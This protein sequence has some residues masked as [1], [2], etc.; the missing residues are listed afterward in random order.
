MRDTLRR[1][2]TFVSL[3]EHCFGTCIAETVFVLLVLTT[4]GACGAYIVFIA[5]VLQSLWP[6]YSLTFFSGVTAAAVAPFLL[7][8]NHHMLVWSSSIGNVAVAFVV[9]ATLVQ[10]AEL[11]VW[12]PMSSYLSFESSTFMEAFGIVGFLYAISPTLLTIEKSMGSQRRHF[13][14]AYLVATVVVM[15]GW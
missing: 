9:I 10:G 6:A 2:M 12:Q 14:I 13:V 4:L 8:R 3:T 1:D 11:V 5:S 15:V 7:V